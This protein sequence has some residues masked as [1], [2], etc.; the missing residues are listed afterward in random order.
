[1]GRA[2][3]TLTAGP[4]GAEGARRKR[5]QTECR[6]R[7]I[8]FIGYSRIRGIIATTGPAATGTCTDVT[9]AASAAVAASA[10]GVVVVVDSFNG[11]GG[12]VNTVD[13]AWL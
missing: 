2:R 4:E 8:T 5:V 9:I 11:I 12:H 7:G 6:I 3:H 1:M 13:S 10:V